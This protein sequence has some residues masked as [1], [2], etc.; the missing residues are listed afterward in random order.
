MRKQAEIQYEEQVGKI[1]VETQEFKWQKETLQNQKETL[2]KQH[3]E[4]MAVLKK[5]LPMKM[6]V[7]EEDKGKYQLATE[8]KE[9]KRRIEGNIKSIILYR[10]KWVKW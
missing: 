2:A 6:C 8:I 5:Q 9:K 3:K 10:R 4:A 7:L 1:V